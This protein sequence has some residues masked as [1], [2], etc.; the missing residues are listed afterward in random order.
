MPFWIKI[1]IS[2]V[3]IEALGGLGAAI[4]SDHIGGW[5]TT[6]N[7][8]PGTPPN[9]LFGPVWIC[10]FGLMGTAFAIVW[11]RAP[12]GPPKRKAMLCFGIQLALNI[13]WTPVFFGMHQML[14]ALLVIV[15]LVV[16]DVLTMVRFWLLQP[17]AVVLLIT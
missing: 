10:L 11:E 9:W 8:P 16:A 1:V 7:R 3:A 4:T 13:A 6:L 2:V 14:L 17:L 12:N 15:A 5:F